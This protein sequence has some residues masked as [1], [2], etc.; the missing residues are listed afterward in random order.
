MSSGMPQ[1]C[2]CLWLWPSSGA[3]PFAAPALARDPDRRRLSRTYAAGAAGLALLSLLIG[4]L[5]L[6]LLWPAVS[7]GLVAL[8]YACFGAGGFQ[9]RQDGAMSLAARALLAP[10]L[11]GAWANSRWWTRHAPHPAAIGDEVSPGMA[12]RISGSGAF[13]ACCCAAGF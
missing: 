13:D 5:A 11:L 10:Y 4:G 9:K 12:R 8:N 2:I 1:H 6:W 7:L 3:S